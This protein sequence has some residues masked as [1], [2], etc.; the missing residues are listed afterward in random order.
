MLLA[1]AKDHIQKA[2]Q[3]LKEGK[4][5]DAERLSG[6]AS[7]ADDRLVEPLAI[8][9]ALRRLSKDAAG[10][11][12]MTKLAAPRMTE[13]VFRTLVDFYCSALA[14]GRTAC[15]PVTEPLPDISCIG[16]MFHMAEMHP[17]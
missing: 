5:A 8:K 10:E 3:A 11:K 4:T 2:E 13:G 12:L 15:V 7:C 9:A 14:L 16:H 6:I 1:L 17:A